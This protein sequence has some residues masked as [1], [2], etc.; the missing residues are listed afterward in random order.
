MSIR[1]FY[2]LYYLDNKERTQEEQKR[3]K[4]LLKMLR[5]YDLIELYNEFVLGRKKN[6]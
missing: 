3:Y 6:G 4:L 5:T 2:E 1:N